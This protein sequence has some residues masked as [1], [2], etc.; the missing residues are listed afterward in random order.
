MIV[1]M[2]AGIAAGNSILLQALHRRPGRPNRRIGT[3]T[4]R[5]SKGIVKSKGLRIK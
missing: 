2:G 4:K 3:P 5:I 1:D